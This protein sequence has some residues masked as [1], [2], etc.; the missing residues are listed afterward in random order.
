MGAI[1]KTQI[2]NKNKKREDGGKKPRPAASSFHQ[3][4]MGSGQTG[5]P[6]S[7]E[8]KDRY[9]PNSSKAHPTSPV[10]GPKRIVPVL[11][12]IK[13]RYILALLLCLTFNCFWSFLANQR[14]SIVTPYAPHTNAD[15]RGDP[16]HPP[17]HAMRA[18]HEPAY[19]P[20]P[21]Y[22]RTTYRYQFA[23]WP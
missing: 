1:P 19:I 8:A 15:V 14:P 6:G 13:P 16:L 11:G 23:P 20:R 9:I 22:I 12:R 5:I 17:H 18:T 10:I 3:I 2:T 4:G 21:R 7:I